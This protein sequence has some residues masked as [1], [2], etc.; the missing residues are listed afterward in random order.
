MCVYVFVCVYMCVCVTYHSNK[1][2]VLVCHRVRAEAVEANDV[3]HHLVEKLALLVQARPWAFV[4]EARA[5]VQKVFV[6]AAFVELIISSGDLL[7]TLHQHGGRVRR[8]S[9]REFG[10]RCILHNHP[11]HTLT[12]GVHKD[13]CVGEVLEREDRMRA[14]P[15]KTAVDAV[16]VRVLEAFMCQPGVDGVNYG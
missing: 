1:R 8:N 14:S 4:D 15:L 10:K 3:L 7:F 12:K 9:V 13:L 5:N 11:T 16:E 6:D 2:A